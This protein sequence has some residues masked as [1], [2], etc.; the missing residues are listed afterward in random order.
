MET[1]TK[2]ASAPTKIKSITTV[3]GRTFEGT[4]FVEADYEGDLLARAGV[5]YSVGRES[6]DT[7]NESLAG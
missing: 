2:D 1:V 4:V 6:S 7:Y 3:D 5:S